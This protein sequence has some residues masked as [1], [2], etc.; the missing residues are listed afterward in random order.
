MADAFQ[1]CAI[2]EKS[3]VSSLQERLSGTIVDETLKGDSANILPVGMK[4]TREDFIE[5]LVDGLDV[6]SIF[7][8]RFKVRE[9]QVV[10]NFCIYL[11]LS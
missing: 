9:K 2:N 1:S 8:L 11:I 10:V 4:R 3:A 6:A 5:I 7:C